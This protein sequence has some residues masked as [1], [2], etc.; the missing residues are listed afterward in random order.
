MTQQNGEGARPVEVVARRVREVRE[1]RGLSGA[2]LAERL[3]AV[4]LGWDRNVVAN[5]ENGRRASVDVAELLALAYVLDVAPI[6]L[7]VPIDDK[8]AAYQVTE[9]L[10]AE[11]DQVRAWVR[12][13]QG[14][15]GT[16]L[17]DFYSEAPDHEQ[18]IP[19]QGAPALDKDGNVVP[20]TWR[21]RRLHGVVRLWLLRV[22]GG[23]RF[24]DEEGDG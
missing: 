15:A 17:R 12:G 24:A 5:L 7:L 16:T 3:R 18:G 22:S 8:T 13:F 6:H 2:K 4:G 21:Q 20:S 9:N 1:R 19:D 14:L 11:V 23:A 10:M